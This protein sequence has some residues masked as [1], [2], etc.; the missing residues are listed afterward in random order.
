M[1]FLALESGDLFLIPSS[2]LNGG[3]RLS[4]CLVLSVGRAGDEIRA[5]G[6]I[7]QDEELLLK[8]FFAE[9]SEVERDNEVTR[10]PPPSLPPSLYLSL[11]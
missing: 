10:S 5:M 1:T 3:G 6:E 9:V 8:S 7:A 11:C 2:K 4:H